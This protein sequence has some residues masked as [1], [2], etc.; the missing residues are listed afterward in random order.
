MTTDKIEVN[1]NLDMLE[2]AAKTCLVAKDPKI[3]H[4]YLLLANP[5]TMLAMIKLIR[6]LEERNTQLQTQVAGLEMKKAA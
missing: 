1:L 3:D 6:D 5:V 2:I 4:A